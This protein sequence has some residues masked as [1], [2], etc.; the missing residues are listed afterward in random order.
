MAGQI[1]AG[2]DIP[3]TADPELLSDKIALVAGVFDDH[4]SARVDMPETA[5]NDDADTVDALMS[6]VQ[7]KARFMA[8]FV[9]R[10]RR[11]GELHV[12]G[13]A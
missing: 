3:V 5:R 12:G 9:G 7:G 1:T 11:A 2:G 4:E 10:R 13:I 6:A 8:N